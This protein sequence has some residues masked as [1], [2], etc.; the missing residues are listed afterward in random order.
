MSKKGGWKPPFSF[1][2]MSLRE[3]A[4][5]R[6]LPIT[7]PGAPEQ[8]GVLFVRY[9][10]HLLRFV[11]QVVQQRT[12][13]VEGEGARDTWR[14]LV[15][16]AVTHDDLL[17]SGA[18]QKPQLLDCLPARAGERVKSTMREVSSRKGVSPVVGLTRGGRAPPLLSAYTSLLDGIGTGDTGARKGSAASSDELALAAS[19]SRA[20]RWFST[21]TEGDPFLWTGGSFH[22]SFAG[23]C[24]NP[25]AWGVR[26]RAYVRWSADDIVGAYHQVVPPGP[27][28]TIMLPCRKCWPCQLQRRR[29]WI[30]RA[31]NEARLAKKTYFLTGTFREKPD[32][33]EEVV[34]EYQRFMKR[35][36]KKCPNDTLRY[37]AVLE[38][39]EKNGRLHV[40]CLLHTTMEWQAIKDAWIAGFSKLNQ[41]PCR[42]DEAG[43][44]DEESARQLMYVAGYVTGDIKFKVRASLRYGKMQMPQ[45]PIVPMRM[46]AFI[47]TVMEGEELPTIPSR[48]GRDPL[49][50]S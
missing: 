28:T 8:F 3:R 7:A 47:Q 13:R 2:G 10:T 43:V 38:R 19:E 48:E 36:R 50:G 49:H 30:A 23:K 44:L 37:L 4:I 20:K 9:K 39:G 41:V 35:V 21:E 32:E 1:D 12:K 15:C 34:A 5:A 24:E 27:E 16:R 11:G 22:E 45:I 33:P 46:D 18:V 29:E 6:E 42:F 40:H 25:F 17:F 26:Q 31:I 14:P